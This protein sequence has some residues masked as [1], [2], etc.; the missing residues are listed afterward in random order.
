MSWAVIAASIYSHGAGPSEVDPSLLNIKRDDRCESSPSSSAYITGPSR[1]PGTTRSASSSEPP[2]D[3]RARSPSTAESG[4]TCTPNSPPPEGS[5][6]RHPQPRLGPPWGTVSWTTT[7]RALHASTE[8]APARR[9]ER[10]TTYEKRP[11]S[12]RSEPRRNKPDKCMD[13]ATQRRDHARTQRRRT[14]PR[15]LKEAT[16]H[17]ERSDTRNMP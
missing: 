10:S 7:G 5:S 15:G 1:A 3:E 16:N 2:Q 11:Q 12:R 17:F 9:T 8:L 6:L 4:A 13:D 14:A